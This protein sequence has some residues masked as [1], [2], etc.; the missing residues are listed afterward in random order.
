MR[1]SFILLILS[2]LC[3]TVLALDIK[4][5]IQWNE[6]CPSLSSLGQ[7][8]VVLDNGKLRGGITRDGSF[9]IPDVPAGTYILSVI[10]H[11]HAFDKAS[12]LRIDVLEAETLPEVRPYIPG[13]PLSPPST[14][15]LPYPV[16]LP[17]RQTSDYFVP[18]QS[19]NL[20]G[21]FQSPMT[22]MMLGM[23]VLVLAMPTLMKNMDPEMVQDINKRQ[24][25]I[26]T[27]QNSLQS[28]DLGSGLSALINTGDD[29]KPPAPSAMKQS[30]SAGMKHRSGKGKK[31]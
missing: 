26:S 24:A 23:G 22:L 29:E 30:A 3:Y 15:T 5:R 17:A 31:R 2:S 18:H 8:K 14:V 25:R 28:G 20:L 9:V 10:A 27:F 19:F 13:T 7:A 16:V 6:L 21:M 12:L 4:G 11:D 1:V